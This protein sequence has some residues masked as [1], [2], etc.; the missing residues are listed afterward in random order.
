MQQK[1]G[2]ETETPTPFPR[3]VVNDCH[4]G[5]FNFAYRENAYCRSISPSVTLWRPLA[6][7]KSNR[8]T[9]QLKIRSSRASFAF[10]AASILS[11]L[12]SQCDGRP[13][14]LEVHGDIILL[15]GVS[16]TMILHNSLSMSLPINS[17]K[18][19]STHWIL[20]Y[21]ALL[22]RLYSQSLV[23]VDTP[24]FADTNMSSAEISRMI[25]G[26]KRRGPQISL[27]HAVIDFV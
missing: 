14:K 13:R 16:L 4:S 22:E 23:L 8:T 15:Q 7:E 6:S 18:G 17:A 20:A 26:W 1:P 10:L 21:E 24:G 19:F 9:S 12:S 27:N 11:T 3:G 5:I 25:A 2:L